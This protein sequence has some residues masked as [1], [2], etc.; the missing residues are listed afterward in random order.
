MHVSETVLAFT[1]LVVM[2]YLLKKKGILREED[3]G[4]FARLLTNAVLPATIFYQL[5]T[6][7]LTGEIIVPIII[8]FL[9]GIVSLALSYLAGRALKFDRQSIGALMIVSSFGSSALIGYPVIQ[10]AFA[11]NP[12]AFAHGIII[13]ELGV[14]LPIFILCPA[15]AMY[16][17]GSFKGNN[18]DIVNVAK[19]YFTSPIFI[20]VVSGMVLSKIELPQAHVVVTIQEALKMVQGSLVV[21]SA[22]ILGL[23]LTFTPMKGFWA[24]IIFSIFVQMLFQVWFC[25]TMSNILGVNQVNKEILVLISAMPAAILGPV[26]A[27]QYDCAAKTATLLTFTHIVI[28]PVVVPIVFTFFS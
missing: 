20:A 23:Q 18:N 14:G 13:S 24:L 11:G 9:S 28:S 15:V 8:M 25:G 2:A 1:L 4:I 7:P 6:Y 3:S 22:V 21:V 5:W 16:F 19:D 26:F 10:Y 27:T 17:G 12:E